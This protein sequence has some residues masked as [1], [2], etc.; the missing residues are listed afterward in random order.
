M[1]YHELKR[2]T[3]QPKRLSEVTDGLRKKTL[4]DPFSSL[5]IVYY[6]KERYY[7]RMYFQAWLVF[8]YDKAYEMTYSISTWD[9][10]GTLALFNTENMYSGHDQS[11][12]DSKI[13]YQHMCFNN[14]W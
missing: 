5:K 7:L 13:I 8:Y 11:E 14:Y 2:D 3:K 1:I 4:K 6:Y 12:I 10:Y 9:Q